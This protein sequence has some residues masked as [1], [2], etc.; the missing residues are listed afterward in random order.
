MAFFHAQDII[1][2]KFLLPAFNQKAV[3]IK[4]ENDCEDSDNP[5]SKIHD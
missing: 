4:Q 1:Q 5:A 2:A 3:C